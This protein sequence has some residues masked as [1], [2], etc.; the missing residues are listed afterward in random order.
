MISK[1]FQ[2]LIR[3]IRYEVRGIQFQWV[4]AI[5]L[6]STWCSVLH[7]LHSLLT[8]S[9]VG[10]YAGELDGSVVTSLR[11]LFVLFGHSLRGVPIRQPI[12]HQEHLKRPLRIYHWKNATEVKRTYD[13][14]FQ[15]TG[16]F[17][18]HPQK[19]ILYCI[20]IPWKP[21]L[22]LAHGVI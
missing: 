3:G 7:L 16:I 6:G 5:I 9:F 8:H 2:R 10:I 20:A 15:C 17:G 1:T 19:D 12:I 14:P 22:S 21:F 11:V 18:I 13:I 4:E